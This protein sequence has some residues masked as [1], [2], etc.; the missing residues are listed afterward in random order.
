MTVQNISAVTLGVR[1]MAR[2]V[3]FYR[4]KVEL[5]M[6]YGGEDAGFTSFKVG[7]AFLNLIA[8][9]QPLTWWG[10]TIFHVDDVDRM[11]AKLVNA[12]LDAD[13]DPADAPWGERY[14]HITDPDGH[15]L[16]FARF[17]DGSGH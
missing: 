2:S 4:D 7:D 10:R 6:L 17:L 11:H 16:S 12:G 15:E 13:T 3:V 5:E 1:D 8:T 9:D 14:F